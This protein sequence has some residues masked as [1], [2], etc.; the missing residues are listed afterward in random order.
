ME[1]DDLQ[2]F[3]IRDATGSLTTPGSPGDLNPDRLSGPGADAMAG[4]GAP[5]DPGG[6]LLHLS[7]SGFAKLLLV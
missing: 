5:G 4:R 2:T 7:S 6:F 1:F 3:L